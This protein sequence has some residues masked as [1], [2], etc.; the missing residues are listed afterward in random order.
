MARPAMRLRLAPMFPAKVQATD[1]LEVTRT[2]GVLTVGQDWTPIQESDLPGDPSEYDILFFDRGAASYSRVP[3]DQMITPGADWSTLPGKPSTFPPS[4]HSHPTSA[5]IGLDDALAGKLDDTQ[6]TA[7]GLAMLGAVSAAAQ[8]A[9]LSAFTGDSGAGGVKGLVPAPASGDDGAGKFLSAGGT[10]EPP[11]GSPGVLYDAVLEGGCD[12][13]G[14]SVTG[15]GV[16]AAIDAATTAGR[17]CYFPPGT[18]DITGTRIRP[19]SG[20]RIVGAGYLLSVFKRTTNTNIGTVECFG[21]SDVEIRGI[22]I[23][24][25]AATYTLGYAQT[26]FCAR[27]G[28]KNIRFIDCGVT[29]RMNRGFHVLNSRDCRLIRCY[30]LGNGNA[31]YR[32]VCD[33]AASGVAGMSDETSPAQNSNNIAELCTFDGAETDGSSTQYTSYGIN[34]AGESG[35]SDQVNRSRIIAC[36]TRNFDLQGIEMGGKC[37]DSKAI[38]C[39]VH[40]CGDSGGGFGALFQLYSG[41]GCFGCSMIDVS[42]SN[43]GYGFAAYSANYCKFVATHARSNGVDGYIAQ[44]CVGCEWAGAVAL[45]NAGDGFDVTNV[46]DCSFSNVISSV[47][48]GVGFRADAT[49]DS[50][51]LYAGVFRTNTAGSFSIAWTNPSGTNNRS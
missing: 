42:V 1:G 38:S 6:A 36:I 41:N 34:L 33:F 37:F 7:S 12:N 14:G 40:N 32:E 49:S 22:G 35:G 44:N 18:Y 29:G 28:S 31:A 25:T 9:L 10:W 15:A 21:V 45:S 50:N 3:A 48:T 13:T 4:T 23:N 51:A 26:G 47:N 20:A 43:S 39:N 16:Q 11:P 27:N 46:D 19:P 24:Y 8:T 30:T 5:I 2:G 17:P